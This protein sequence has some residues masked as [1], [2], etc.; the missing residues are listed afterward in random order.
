[1]K[2]FCVF[3]GKKPEEKNKEHIIPQWLIKMTGN[4]KRAMNLGVDLN[5]FEKDGTLK[6]RTFSFNS[7][8]FPAC[9]KCNSDFS[10]LETKVKGYFKRL[11]ENDYFTNDEID[12]LLDWFDKVRIGLWLG[13]L[14]LNKAVDLVEPKFHI[15]NRMGKRDRCLFIYETD[16]KPWK[17]IQFIGFNSPGFHFIPSCFTLR[18]NN[19]YFFNYSF[20]FLLL[21]N[22][23]FPYPS[24]FKNNEIDTR[25]YDIEISEGIEKIRTPLIPQKFMR[26]SSQ[27]YQPIIPPEFI[28]EEIEYLYK[29]SLYVQNNCL[30][31]KTGKGDI[32]YLDNSIKKLHNDSELILTGG[33]KHNEKYFPEKI[34]QQTFQSITNQLKRKTHKNLKDENLKQRLEKTRRMVMDAHN[35]YVKIVLKNKKYS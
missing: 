19:I 12:T 9:E 27:I 32:F 6:L 17:G 30:D 5:Q 15:K 1:M 7:F 23:G 3:C 25:K 28:G 29:E 2:K 35:E 14:T 21:K 33:T 31:Y 10:K 8:H 24:Q 13:S 16:E 26:A 18:V 22:M 4:P 11:F 34:A 20:D